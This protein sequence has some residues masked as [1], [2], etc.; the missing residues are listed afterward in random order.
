M[1]EYAVANKL[2]ERGFGHRKKGT[3]L[4]LYLKGIIDE[5]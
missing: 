4:S 2:V 1:K 3:R 5:M